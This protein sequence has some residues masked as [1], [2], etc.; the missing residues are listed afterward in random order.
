MKEEFQNIIDNLSSQISSKLIL[1]QNMS[2]EDVIDFYYHSKTF[3]D[4]KNP[5]S[6]LYTKTVD[7]LYDL[8][9]KELV[10]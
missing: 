6:G 8:I 4:L 7:E 9:V 1:K 10:E 5:D 2:L 3:T